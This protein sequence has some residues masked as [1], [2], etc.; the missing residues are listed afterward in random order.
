MI[1]IMNKL[2]RAQKQLTQ[3]FGREATPEELAD[4]MH[5]PVSRINSLLKMAQQPV[6]LHAPVGD[7]GDVSVGD[8]IEDK[9]A[10]NPSDV[11]SYSLLIVSIMWT[12]IRM[13]RAW[14]AMA[15]V[16]AWRIHH[17]A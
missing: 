2:W 5:M 14:S 8:F 6:S 17:V 16:M 15:R 10:E 4:E 9:S 7:D 3:E 13:V 11:T 1:E 12:G